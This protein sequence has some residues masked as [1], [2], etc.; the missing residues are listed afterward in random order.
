MTNPLLDVLPPKVR[1][2]LYAVL[3]VAGAVYAAY[4]MAGGDWG[5]AIG[6]LLAAF[7]GATA[8]ANT[9]KAKRVSAGKHEAGQADVGLILLVLTF[10]GVLL[11]L[12]RVHL[13]G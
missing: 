9:P 6:S 11:L 5:I 10:V 2:Y 8:H 4:E 1:Q 12:F 13:G 3:F 7:T